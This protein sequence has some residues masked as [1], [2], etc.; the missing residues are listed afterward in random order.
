MKKKKQLKT[1][2]TKVYRAEKVNVVRGT[3]GV[4]VAL[5]QR[6]VLLV[7]GLVGS[8]SPVG[9]RNER[10]HQVISKHLGEDCQNKEIDHERDNCYMSSFKKNF[11]IKNGE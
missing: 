9:K 8:A 1:I 2:H 6:Q 5:D 3:D 4:G 11:L 10:P 7:E